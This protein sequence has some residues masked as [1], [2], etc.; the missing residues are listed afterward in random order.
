MALL[1][2]L[3]RAGRYLAWAVLFSALAALAMF[4]RS[5]AMEPVY[6]SKVSLQAVPGE[7]ESTREAV[8]GRAAA[9]ALDEGGRSATVTDDRLVVEVTASASDEAAKRATAVAAAISDSIAAGSL[10][11]LDDMI[12][13]QRQLTADLQGRLPEA[14]P[15][16]RPEL[17]RQLS[18]GTE[19]LLQLEA[20]APDRLEL[21]AAPTVPTSPVAPTPSRDAGIAFALTLAATSITALF[22]AARADRFL[23]RGLGADVIRLTEAPLLAVVAGEEEDRREAV[24]A[25]RGAL[26]LLPDLDRLRTLA[27]ITPDASRAASSLVWDLTKSVALLDAAVVAVDA[28]LRM[29]RLHHLA[30]LPRAPGLSDVLSGRTEIDGVV[31]GKAPGFVGAGFETDDPISLLTTGELRA[32]LESIDAELVIVDLPPAMRFGDA[33]AVAPAVDAT[34]VVIDPRRTRR[35]DVA[36]LVRQLRFV[37]AHVAGVV[38]VVAT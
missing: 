15:E 19:T 5:S 14:T 18:E 30:S 21:A 17:E 27:V 24:A 37:G 12:A 9:V 23:R 33:M 4:I 22:A 20:T 10:R 6:V 28:N 3:R 2:A 13:R 38:A 16:A 1:D 8:L 26:L 36:D 32:V 31:Q 35:R 25:V 7:A 11:R 34:L 29:P